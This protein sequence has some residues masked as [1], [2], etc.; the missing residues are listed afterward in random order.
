MA[1]QDRRRHAVLVVLDTARADVFE[2]YGAGA[3]ASPALGDLARRGWAA[4]HAV[5]SSSWTLPSHVGMLLGTPHR[6][7]GLV[8]ET[9]QRPQAARPVLDAN[10]SRYLPHVL[11]EHG[12]R[13][14]G[15][16]AN[17]WLQESSG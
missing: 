15:G 8:R 11:H 9:Q 1:L 6:A 5:A 4:P 16:S 10:R 7:A 3:G 2:P 14:V 12:F 13:T 17:P